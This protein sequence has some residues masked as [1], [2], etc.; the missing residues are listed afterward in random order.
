MGQANLLGLA[1]NDAPLGFSFGLRWFCRLRSRMCPITNSKEKVCA[2][3][4]TPVSR[5][6]AH[7]MTSRAADGDGVFSKIFLCHN[8]L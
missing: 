7:R 6:A 5:S 3:Q 8:G 2:T 4:S 1:R